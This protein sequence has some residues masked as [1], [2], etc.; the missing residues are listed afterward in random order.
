MLHC[1]SCIELPLKQMMMMM[2]M[3]MP[4]SVEQ[5]RRWRKETTVEVM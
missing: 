4:F 1:L 5:W 3:A 2:M